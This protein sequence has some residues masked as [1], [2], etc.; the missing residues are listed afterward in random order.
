MLLNKTVAASQSDIISDGV[1]GNEDA[2]SED[3]INNF[4]NAFSGSCLRPSN[5]PAGLSPATWNEPIS[6]T[7]YG[8]DVSAA[9]IIWKSAK[10]YH[11]NPQVILATLEK[12]QGIVSGNAR[13]GCSRTVYNS[14]MGYNCPDSSENALKSYPNI[15]IGDDQKTCVQR[16]QNATFSRQVNHAA[17]QLSFDAHRAYGDISW[18]DDGAVTYGGFMTQGNRARVQNGSIQYYDGIANIDG[19]SIQVANGPTAALY[20]YTPHFNS[21]ETI[22]TRWFGTTHTT[23]IPGCDAATNT[24]LSCV[25]K[26]R[27]PDGSEVITTSFGDINYYVNNLG[28]GY[29]GMIF[30]SRNQI[31]PSSGNIP[32][33]AMTKSSGATFLTTNLTEYNALSGS[34]TPNGILFYADPA[35][36]N[37]GYSVYRLYNSQNQQH[38]WTTRPYDY[39]SSYVSEGVVFSAL[40]PVIQEVAPAQGQNLVYRFR[41]LPNNVHFWTTDV[42]ERDSMIR[43]G[44]TYDGVGWKSV[45]GQTGTVVYRMYSDGLKQHL[46]TTS[47]PEVHDLATNHNWQ[48]EGVAMYAAS[49]G[50]PVFRLYRPQT[51]EHFY[52]TDSNER[53]FLI[54]Q[55]VFLD[56]GIAWYQP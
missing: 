51:G 8:G 4:I 20:N 40:S 35:N 34:F 22:F 3:Q 26:A 45:Q 47:W 42:N 29:V 36:S 56:E 2:M 49:N 44:Y 50:T 15:G 30:L 23:N 52:T 43:A 12:E 1:F 38:V 19:T 39:P 16:E 5:Y 41:N 13:Y 25:W 55:G 10:L 28:Y 6:Y 53:Q 31:S 37:S 46:Y 14:A 21:F 24:S 17:W 11:I 27:K 7:V 9:R 48:Y 18:L 33:Y 54:S 32:V